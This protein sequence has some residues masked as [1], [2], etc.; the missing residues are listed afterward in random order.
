MADKAMLKVLYVEDEPDLRDRIRIVLE[1]HFETVLVAGNGKEGLQLFRAE[2]P[3][4]VVSDIRMPVMDGL[5]LTVEV[6]RLAPGT[7]VILCTAFTETSYLLKA[8]ELG[9]S[10]YVRKPLDCQELV[11][12]ISTAALHILQHNELER[13][14]D[15]EQAS[16]EL[17]L[18]TSPAIQEAIRQARRIA[19]SDFSVVI[20]GETGVGKSHLASIIHGL[21]RR[22]QQPFVTVTVSAIPEQLVESQLFGHLKGAF[23]GAVSSTRGLFEEADGGT[24]FLD[25][26]DCAPAAVQAKLLHAVERKQFYRIGGV[27]P[28][29]VD[30][31]IITASNRDLLQ[32]VTRGSFREDLYYRL[33]ETVVTL[34]ALR[35]RGDDILLLARRFLVD[36]ARELDRVPPRIAADAALV[37]NRHPWPGNVREL[38]SIMKRVALFATETIT[39]PDLAGILSVASRLGTQEPAA[40]SVQSLE[41]LKRDAVRQALA[42]TGGKKMEAARLLDVDYSS[43]KRMLDRY[44]IA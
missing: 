11:H 10:A 2:R 22:R 5:E 43:F 38:K 13:S 3:D 33:G 21:S 14:R 30:T 39:A 27:Q 41:D 34:P 15:T 36:A 4:V 6:R 32:E 20:Q 25:D 9:V 7:P 35:E 42:A 1:M 29:T 40:R 8:I 23:T 17:L 28:T 12:S 26:V 31:R 16:L 24:L 37:L 19:Q 18:G 44:G